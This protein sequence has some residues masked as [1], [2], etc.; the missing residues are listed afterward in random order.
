[1]TSILFCSKGCLRPNDRVTDEQTRRNGECDHE[2]L[3]ELLLTRCG[4]SGCHGRQSAEPDTAADQQHD[5]GQQDDGCRTSCLSSPD[6]RKDDRNDGPEQ[7]SEVT[8]GDG[9]AEKNR[10]VGNGAAEDS[11]E[12]ISRG[13]LKDHAKPDDQQWHKQPEPL[14]T[15][16]RARGRLN[17]PE[18]AYDPDSEPGAGKLL[19][20]VDQPAHEIRSTGDDAPAH[21]LDDA[22]ADGIA[23]DQDEDC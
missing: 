11:P 21:Q 19:D 6:V 4:L 20:Q 9:S 16:R 22:Y 5:G 18:K 14:G 2:H 7:V 3:D 12:E 13:G 8:P 17:R 15:H 10:T 23:R 1:M